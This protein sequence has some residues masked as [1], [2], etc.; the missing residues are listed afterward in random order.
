M[1]FSFILFILLL[2]CGSTGTDSGIRSY[3]GNGK[4]MA[5]VKVKLWK[6]LYGENRELTG[7]FVKSFI[8]LLITGELE[9]VLRFC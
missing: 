3:V 1:S 9:F 7:L 8:F 6:S 4:I 5:G 2:W